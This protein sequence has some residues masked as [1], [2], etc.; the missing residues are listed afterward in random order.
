MFAS[1]TL[2]S[3]EAFLRGGDHPH[4]QNRFLEKGRTRWEPTNAG[5]ELN[6]HRSQLEGIAKMAGDE[7]FLSDIPV[8]RRPTATEFFGILAP[9]M[10]V[11]ARRGIDRTGNIPLEPDPP[12]LVIGIRD[13]DG[14]HQRLRIGMPRI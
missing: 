6:G 7:V 3:P 11:A 12:G 13:R 5:K 8:F 1:P 4:T 14:R 9:G 10:E 2:A